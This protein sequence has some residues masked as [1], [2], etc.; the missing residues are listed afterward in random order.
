MTASAAKVGSLASL[1]RYPI[2]SMMGE[3][4]NSVRVTPR[5]VFG[6]R[7]FALC[8]R[9]TKKIVSAKNPRKWPN[10][11]SYRAAYVNPPDGSDPLPAVRVTLPDGRM[12]VSSSAD[13][14]QTLS[15]SLGRAVTLLESPPPDAQLEEYWPVLE[16]A[17]H[18]DVVTD[19]AMPPG[20]FF[21]LAILHVLTTGTLDKL[22]Q[23][24]PGGRFEPRR[25]RPNLIINTGSDAGFVENQ[26]IGKTLAIGSQV[27]IEI[28]GPCPRCV[29][30]TL[31]QGDLP[32][33]PGILKTA[34]QHNEVR[35]GV[36]AKVVQ[37][38]A[39]KIG[40]AVSVA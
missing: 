29:M 5:G 30:T 35:V 22:R 11:F 20:T 33:D 3:E 40:D 17:T 36:Y 25:F 28:T 8:D 32:K 24:Y 34:A 31:A 18:Q 12:S 4:L 10:M 38:G 27:K 6:D 16:G 13:F 19:E 1:H 21:D 23:L 7:A 39:I 15:E 14:T 2:K 9:E 26:W 37:A